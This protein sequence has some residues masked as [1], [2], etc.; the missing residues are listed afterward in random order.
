MAIFARDLKLP[1]IIKGL[2][3][4]MKAAAKD[5]EFEE[6]TRLRNTLK[7]LKKKIW[8][9]KAALWAAYFL[10]SVFPALQIYI[11]S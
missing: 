3:A 5:L 2:T 10:P 7:E 11:Y 4:K 6:A 8:K 9:L 1:Q